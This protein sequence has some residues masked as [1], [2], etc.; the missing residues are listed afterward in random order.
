MDRLVLLASRIF[1]TYE[2]Y[3]E[4]SGAAAR[5]EAVSPI[6]ATGARFSS[7]RRRSSADDL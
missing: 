1:E 2:V 6:D 5:F 3:D 4:G 7:A